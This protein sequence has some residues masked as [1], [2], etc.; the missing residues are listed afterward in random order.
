[1]ELLDVNEYIY[2]CSYK[3]GK[4]DT[5]VAKAPSAANSWCMA[6]HVLLSLVCLHC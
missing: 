4:P 5:V 2:I 6:L 3:V 1:M